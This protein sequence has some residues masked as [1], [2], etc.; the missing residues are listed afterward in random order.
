MDPG[1]PPLP[2]EDEEVA[3]RMM[4]HQY[5]HADFNEAMQQLQGVTEAPVGDSSV[6]GAA[7]NQDS[8]NLSETESDCQVPIQ[9]TAKLN[10]KLPTPKLG[11]FL[12]PTAAASSKE[13]QRGPQPF[14]RPGQR[15]GSIP[16]I[17]APPDDASVLD[18]S[19]LIMIP[20]PISEEPE[21]WAPPL[22]PPD[23]Q[24]AEE[25]DAR[26]GGGGGDGNSSEAAG[27]R[28]VG[29]G[30]RWGDL[31]NLQTLEEDQ[32]T[33][34]HEIGERHRRM[35]RM[36]S[37]KT[38]TQ[39]FPI[40]GISTSV[41]N[42]EQVV[43]FVGL[44]KGEMVM[45]KAFGQLLS[46]LAC[47][48]MMNSLEQS[49]GDLWTGV[50]GFELEEAWGWGFDNAANH[51]TRSIINMTSRLNIVTEDW[52]L[53]VSELGKDAFAAK[54]SANLMNTN[55]EKRLARDLC[56]LLE[57]LINAVMD[58]DRLRVSRDT[59]II[60]QSWSTIVA[61]LAA[62]VGGPRETNNTGK[63]FYASQEEEGEQ[64]KE[65]PDHRS[66]TRRK[67]TRFGLGTV[68]STREEGEGGEN[69][70]RRSRMNTVTST[71]GRLFKRTGTTA[72]AR[73][74]NKALVN[75]REEAMAQQDVEAAQLVGAGEESSPG[76]GV[77]PGEKAQLP[78]NTPSSAMANI[79][80]QDESNTSSTTPE[81]AIIRERLQ[82][83][84]PIAEEVSSQGLAEVIAAASHQLT[85]ALIK[86]NRSD[87]TQALKEAPR[88]LRAKWACAVHI[89][90]ESVSPIYWMISESNTDMASLLLCDVLAIR[91]NKSKVYYGMEELWTT[92]KGAL[93][94]KISNE[95]P[96]LLLDILDGHMW[97][98][99]LVKKGMR[100]VVF[101]V[102]PLWGDVLTPWV[103]GEPLYTC[104]E[105]TL[106]PCIVET[107]QDEVTAHPVTMFIAQRKW[108][109]YAAA[110]EGN[111]Q[112]LYIVM[113]ICWSLG[114]SWL[115]EKGL[116]SQ[117]MRVLALVLSI[118]FMIKVAIQRIAGQV[119]YRHVT[120]RI[121]GVRLPPNWNFVPFHLS[122]PFPFLKLVI[123]GIIA[124][125]I[126]DGIAESEWG[127]VK[128]HPTGRARSLDAFVVTEALLLFIG[129][130][131]ASDS[132]LFYPNGYR[133]IAFTTKAVEVC[134][135]L[136]PIMAITL[137]SFGLA[138]PL[139]GEDYEGFKDIHLSLWTLYSLSF[140]AYRPRFDELPLVVLTFLMIYVLLSTLLLAKLFASLFV[141][142][143]H[144][145]DSQ[146]DRY[147]SLMLCERVVDI[148]FSITPEDIQRHAQ[149][150]PFEFHYFDDKRQGGLPDGLVDYKDLSF[151]PRKAA[152]G[153]FDR[154]E[155]YDSEEGDNVA[156]PSSDVGLESHGAK[157]GTS[158]E[159]VMQ[160]LAAFQRQLTTSTETADKLRR[161]TRSLRTTSGAGSVVGDDKSSLSKS[162][163]SA[164]GVSVK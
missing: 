25:E 145:A 111:M 108:S 45:A 40:D 148:D 77:V 97:A 146:A 141:A 112:L 123:S 155:I 41:A 9:P 67:S 159:S 4:S 50:G 42:P 154:R 3:I 46:T 100:K 153:R 104:L 162:L 15:E 87:L 11:L 115:P 74:D 1:S 89:K 70:E 24:E 69:F 51:L 30:D 113:M 138:L 158:H 140:S 149:N 131:G 36:N 27:E 72:S 88:G 26:P 8:A 144:S 54:L 156:W 124:V 12:S 7:G 52:E 93:V 23:T 150:Q 161:A 79:P 101:F 157:G 160:T 102:K 43:E 80:G 90:G 6:G 81:K 16:P 39:V 94:S 143:I 29:S 59:E 164:A 14:T 73:A 117:L 75:L 56:A 18:T 63:D 122:L 34:T 105:E 119:K 5:D 60:Q 134:A 49:L 107:K 17:Q 110:R 20:Q 53:I 76:G 71:L 57:W 64:K 95:A 83:T 91:A 120:N 139:I 147:G 78:G 121:A 55:H 136:V 109:L 132:V 152:D 129:W 10:F 99:N 127:D 133:F 13:S 22:E 118:A 116:P 128:P 61:C 65:R 96:E 58:L 68:D 31:E 47:Q 44:M 84:P 125:I 32:K 33:E 106:L 114:L 130:V 137:L 2:P 62:D 37:Y 82:A 163:I 48:A 151:K 98:S 38:Q 28:S 35:S 126:S 19:C 86:Q 21:V 85:S 66:D 135:R 142:A 92:H 103:D